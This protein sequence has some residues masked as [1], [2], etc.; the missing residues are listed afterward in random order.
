MKKIVLLILFTLTAM[1]LTAADLVVLENL[2]FSPDSQYF[3]FGQHVILTTSGQAYA[4]A[5]IVD[6]PRN[7]F[8][9]G[10]WQK[11][12][13]VVNMLP[14]KDSRG[15]LYELLSNLVDLKRRYKINHLKQ[16]RMLYTISDEIL[17]EDK[18]TPTAKGSNK[19]S[20]LSFRDFEQAKDYTLTLE[21]NSETVNKQVSA[22][23]HINMTMENASGVITHY[24]I[25]RP[26]LMRSG[27]QSYSIFRVW[28]GPDGKSLVIAI[29][30]KAP[31]LSVRY[32]VETVVTD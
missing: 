15:A 18:L 6:V 7:D 17:D 23:F 2:G 24:T 25:G 3:M 28:V 31:D 30:R 14:N 27:V 19:S 16:G 1:L 10:G 13:W 11:R 21:Q 29:A 26:Y 8:V 20:V 5:A 22:A 32:M 9:P 12:S 4:E